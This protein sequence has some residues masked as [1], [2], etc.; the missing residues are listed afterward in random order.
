M[1]FIQLLRKVF[2]CL[3]ICAA[4]QPDGKAPLAPSA[5]AIRGSQVMLPNFTSTDYPVPHA[6]T[7]EEIQEVIGDFAQAARNAI[8]AG[9]DTKFSV[10]LI[11]SLIRC[12]FLTL[13]A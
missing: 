2:T 10:F 12:D 6:M 1:S 4:Y 11:P 7:V 13:F 8:A 3:F 9:Y 5:L